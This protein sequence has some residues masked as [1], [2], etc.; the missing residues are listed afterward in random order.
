MEQNCILSILNIEKIYYIFI[1]IYFK[2]N[3]NHRAYSHRK[4][5]FILKLYHH[6]HSI[7]IPFLKFIVSAT[8]FIMLLSYRIKMINFKIFISAFLF[9]LS[10][11]ITKIH[12]KHLTFLKKLQNFKYLTKFIISPNLKYQ[13]CQLKEYVKCF[14]YLQH[15]Y[16]LYK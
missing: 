10:I 3:R 16:K 7:R 13:E 4:V 11:K 5:H 2:S 9:T 12:C 15:K 8:L 6:Q 14:Q 1:K